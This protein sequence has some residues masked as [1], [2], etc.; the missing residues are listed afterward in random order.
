MHWKACDFLWA[1][2]REDGGWHSDIHGLMR[3][4]QSL[5]P[6]VLYALMNVPDSIYPMPKKNVEA[7]FTFIRQNVN[8]FGVLGQADPDFIDYPNYATSYALMALIKYDKAEDANLIKKMINY[9]VSEQYVEYRGITEDSYAYGSW[10]IGEETLRDG[11][12]GQ[13]DLSHTRRVL[14]ALRMA[15]H[16]DTLTYS[17]ARVFLRL[18]QK[19]PTEKRTQPNIEEDDTAAVFFDGGFYFSPTALDQNKAGQ[20]PASTTF[21]AHYRSYATATC[22]GIL[23]LLAA[24]ARVDSASI[25]AAKLWLAKNPAIEAPQGIPEEQPGEWDKVLKLYHAYVRAEVYNALDWSGNWKIAM[26][27]WLASEQ[28]PDGRFMN[29]YGGP[30]KENDPVLATAFAIIAV[31]NINEAFGTAL[32]RERA[33]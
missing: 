26:Q 2:Q 10:G 31:N 25:R 24:G 6:F 20:E 23:A 19:D 18:L 11:F 7:A 32:D 33:R 1:Q 17:K 14:Q 22:D 8:G 29:P 28:Q 5:T 12:Y 4:G 27:T 16:E 3:S 30:N 13:L 21:Q 9:L 15:G